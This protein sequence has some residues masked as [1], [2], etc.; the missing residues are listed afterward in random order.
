MF[1]VGDEKQ[2]IYAFRR[3]NPALQAQ[4]SSW[5]AEHLNAVSAPLDSSRRSS[6]AIIDY[7]NAVFDSDEIR[8]HLPGFS[9]HDTHLK[10][11]PGSVTLMPLFEPDEVEDITLTGLRNPL[12]QPRPDAPPSAHDKE[13][14]WIAD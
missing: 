11:L 4:A 14:Q 3:A 13:A 6:P 10:Q 5:L 2:S 9:R 7:V 12:L 1:L 8:Q